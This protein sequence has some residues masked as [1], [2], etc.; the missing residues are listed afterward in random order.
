MQS[1]SCVEKEEKIDLTQ[2]QH[3]NI[4]LSQLRQFGRI[5][6]RSY[7]W[8]KEKQA[9]GHVA[10]QRRE[11]SFRHVQRAR[12]MN[13][14]VVRA[15]RRRDK[16][17]NADH[18]CR[19]CF[20]DVDLVPPTDL[21]YPD[22]SSLP[23][24]CRMKTPCCNRLVCRECVEHMGAWCHKK[25]RNGKRVTRILVCPA[26][27]LVLPTDHYLCTFS[28]CSKNQWT[29]AVSI[30]D[31]KTGD[32]N[33][34]ANRLRPDDEKVKFSQENIAFCTVFDKYITSQRSMNSR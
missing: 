15:L 5:D 12:Q 3:A 17:M 18:V 7:F 32:S 28:K 19:L 11:T 34:V 33:F 2:L 21:K 29:E 1:S 27:G 13:L 31:V 8:K 23:S 30:N 9:Y 6:V 16:S 4:D 14:L 24:P 10:R 26:C 20:Q 22:G 25:S